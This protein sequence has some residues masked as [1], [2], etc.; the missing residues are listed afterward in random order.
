MVR[1]TITLAI[2]F[3]DAT[4]LVG[5]QVTSASAGVPIWLD[6]VR[7]RGTENR[8]ID[9]NHAALG[10]HNCNHNEDAGVACVDSSRWYSCNYS[11]VLCT[12]EWIKKEFDWLC[13]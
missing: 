9:C 6:N 4:P 13:N 11:L 3:S 7:C 1:F 12:V 5:S 8:L 10:V 2:Y